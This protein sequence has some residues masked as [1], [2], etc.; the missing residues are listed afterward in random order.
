MSD[1]WGI[2]HDSEGSCEESALSFQIVHVKRSC[3]FTSYIEASLS[4]FFAAAGSFRRLGII[5]QYTISQS[6]SFFLFFQKFLLL[7]PVM[8]YHRRPSCLSLFAVRSILQV[9]FFGSI[10]AWLTS[11]PCLISH[12][13]QKSDLTACLGFFLWDGCWS[14]HNSL[15]QCCVPFYPGMLEEGIW[16]FR[17]VDNRPLFQ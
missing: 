3:N 1:G 11:W 6:L 12:L 10:F 7:G 4:K 13:F 9:G 2:L 5:L 8:L 15:N 14:I 17:C 16:F